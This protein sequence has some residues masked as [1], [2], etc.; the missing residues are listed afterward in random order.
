MLGNLSFRWDMTENT[1]INEEN[2]KLINAT[3]MKTLS[4]TSQEN[5]KCS[6]DSWFRHERNLIKSFL[7]QNNLTIC[8][9]LAIINL[10]NKG[11]FLNF[12]Q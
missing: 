1:D 7:K 12:Q 10:K 4:V 6:K 9:I 3:L 8:M 11:N 2:I 5:L